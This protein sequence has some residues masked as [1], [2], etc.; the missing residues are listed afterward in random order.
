MKVPSPPRKPSYK[1]FRRMGGFSNS[2]CMAPNDGHWYPHTQTLPCPNT[3][4]LASAVCFPILLQSK[5]KECKSLLLVA[6]DGTAQPRTAFN[7]RKD[8]L[9]LHQLDMY[10]VR[11]RLRLIK[12]DFCLHGVFWQESSHHSRRSGCFSK[13]KNSIEILMSLHSKGLHAEKPTVN[14]R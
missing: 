5:Q 2:R 14:R 9:P 6:L 1:A 13:G 8:P 12:S 3:L 10:T 7:I 4:P 11:E